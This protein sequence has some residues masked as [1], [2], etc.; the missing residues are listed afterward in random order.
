MNEELF[1]LYAKIQFLEEK[2]KELETQEINFQKMLKKY[3]DDRFKAFLDNIEDNGP[4]SKRPNPMFDT[5][6]F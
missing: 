5:D 4:D 6:N 1:K 3:V 2:I